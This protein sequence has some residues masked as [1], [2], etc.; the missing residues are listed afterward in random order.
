MRTRFRAKLLAAVFSSGLLFG[1]TG[2]ADAETLGEA[3]A[4]AYDSNPG[5][6][7]ARSQ[8]RQADETYFRAARTFS[9]TLRADVTVSG[10]TDNDLIPDNS[11][12]GT[13]NA[14]VRVTASGTQQI[15]TG[16][17]LSAQLR[18]QEMQLLSQRE[19]LRTAEQ[20]L[21]S[22]VVTA[23]V[24]VR[25]AEQT[26]AITVESVKNN[27]LSRD[28]AQ[29]KFEVGSSTQTD[30]QLARTRLAQAVTQRIVAEAS[31]QNTRAAYATIVGQLPGTL[32]EEPSIE[33]VLP[34]TVDEATT[35]AMASNPA[36][37]QRILAERSSANGIVSAR[38]AYRPTVSLS[39][40]AS[41]SENNSAA[42]GSSFGGGLDAAGVTTGVT[43][44]I[45]LFAGL[46]TPSTVRSAVEANK[47]DAISIEQQRRS[48]L[49]QVIQN[50]N[51]L[52]SQKAAIVSN[53]EAVASADIT[54][55]GTRLEQQVGLKVTIDV[56]NAEQELRNQQQNLINARFNA[57]TAGVELLSAMGKLDPRV[58]NPAITP[59]DPIAH[60]EE[61]NDFELPWEPLIKTIDQILVPAP[62]PPPTFPGEAPVFT[63]IHGK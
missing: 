24:N 22:S 12:G 29:A 55:T 33:A 1:L 9:P 52:N 23:Y 2:A 44:G 3:I 30:L 39:V 11:Q 49:Q 46:T 53:Q 48:V 32:A 57:Y 28:E 38:S 17:R 51:T 20:T 45:P 14:G 21:V 34:K 42:I 54:L 5:M 36:L 47:S 60:F 7:I 63:D 62:P 61:V 13:S 6:L 35:V 8:L 19:A 40:N 10:G 41:A 59:Y 58:F 50:F 25:R 15:Y 31:L 43:I 16:G 56:L 26:L 18:Q 27:E 37:R 4:M